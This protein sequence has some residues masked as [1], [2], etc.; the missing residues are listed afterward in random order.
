[1][2]R[3]SAEIWCGK[4]AYYVTWKPSPPSSFVCQGL[5][6]ERHKRRIRFSGWVGA[7]SITILQLTPVGDHAPMLFESIKLWVTNEG[8]AGMPLATFV[9]KLIG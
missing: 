8:Y 7:L 6:K 1:M 4:S 3:G 5:K 2:K 9:R